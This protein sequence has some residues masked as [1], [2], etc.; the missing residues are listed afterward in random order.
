MPRS[1]LGSEGKRQLGQSSWE[2]VILTVNRQST[3]L[4]NLTYL[5]SNDFFGPAI[6]DKKIIGE[7][8]YW[9]K[10]SPAQEKFGEKFVLEDLSDHLKSTLRKGFTG[11]EKEHTC[12]LARSSSV[13]AADW[14]VVKGFTTSLYHWREVPNC[15]GLVQSKIVHISWYEFWIMVPVKPNRRPD[16][17][18]CS[19]SVSFEDTFFTRCTSSTNMQLQ[20]RLS[21]RSISLRAISKL[22]TTKNSPVSAN[23]LIGLC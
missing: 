12:A 4:N 14:P 19:A 9:W 20:G 17:N 6:R 8:W 7:P 13:A 18:W 21:R 16:V 2:A 15:P 1:A 10:N 11:A 3:S 22:V 5:I 23:S